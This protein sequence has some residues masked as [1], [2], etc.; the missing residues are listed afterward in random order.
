[1]E[2]KFC[3]KCQQ[4]LSLTLFGRKGKDKPSTYCIACTR[5][6]NKDHYH[7]DIAASRIKKTKNR[8][9]YKDRIR[10]VI[11]EVLECGCVHCGEKDV[12][13]LEFDHID[14]M[15]KSFSLSEVF[16]LQP[17]IDVVMAEIDKCNILC[18]NCHRKRTS[19]Q[20][21]WYKELSR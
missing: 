8:N 21:G 18:S 6:Y 11:L 17:K 9:D 19:K 10:K 16:K 13:C 12:R 14:P 7:K 15:T 3:N 5:Q 20:F 1:M 4:S 2:S